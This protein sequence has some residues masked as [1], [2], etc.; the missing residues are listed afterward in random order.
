[1]YDYHMHSRVSFDGHDTGLSMARAAADAGLRE[2]CF[3]DHVDYGI[4][5]D[6]DQKAEFQYRGGDGRGKNRHVA[7]YFRGIAAGVYGAIRPL[8]K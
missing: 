1:M 7:D 5:K 3:T 8:N 6:W 4:K 2:I